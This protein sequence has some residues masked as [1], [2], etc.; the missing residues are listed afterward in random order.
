MLFEDVEQV[1][2]QLARLEHELLRLAES[3]RQQTE[4]LCAIPGVEQITALT[5]LAEMG[6]DMTVFP[7]AAHA[8]SWAS[9]CPGNCESAGKRKSNRT[10]KG[11]RWMRRALSESAWAVFH[12]NNCHLTAFVD[13]KAAP[14]SSAVAWSP[15]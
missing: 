15:T 4:R 14:I 9:L 7:D 2:R 5:L 11:S 13:R 8:A 10:R 6:A 1:E 3:Y 12:K